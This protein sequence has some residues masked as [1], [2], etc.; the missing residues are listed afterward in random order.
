M[1]PSV[2]C[3]VRRHHLHTD[4]KV[5]QVQ[6]GMCCVVGSGP[7]QGDRWPLRRAACHIRSVHIVVYRRGIARPRDVASRRAPAPRPPPRAEALAPPAPHLCHPTAMHWLFRSAAYLFKRYC[8]TVPMHSTITMYCDHRR[9][10]TPLYHDT[11]F[12]VTCGATKGPW[13]TYK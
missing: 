8:G 3:R 1:E 7:Q 12:V 13:W 4:G 10:M 9:H 5:V 2:C 11:L 6:H